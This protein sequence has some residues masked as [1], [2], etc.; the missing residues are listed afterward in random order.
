[1]PAVMLV[2]ALLR[3]R[4]SGELRRG[5]A[6]VAAVLAGGAALGFWHEGLVSLPALLALLFLA[7]RAGV[8]LGLPS[9]GL[10]ARTVGMLE[11]VLGAVFVLVVGATWPR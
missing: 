5:P 2:R 8:L 3:L 10:R 11:A 1:M 6:L 4:K 9:L 7:V